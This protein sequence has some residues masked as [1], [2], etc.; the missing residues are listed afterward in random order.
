M[1]KILLWD[2]STDGID[3]PLTVRI[4][5]FSLKKINRFFFTFLLSLSLFAGSFSFS[6]LLYAEKTYSVFSSYFGLFFVQ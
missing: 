6:T 5:S 2:P 3:K 1:L 4:G